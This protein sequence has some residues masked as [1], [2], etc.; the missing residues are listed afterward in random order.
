MFI[1][2]NHDQYCFPV[3]RDFDEGT[4]QRILEVKFEDDVKDIP[5]PPDVSNYLISEVSASK[6][7]SSYI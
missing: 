6:M 7:L 5:L 4:L 1:V 3:F 2:V